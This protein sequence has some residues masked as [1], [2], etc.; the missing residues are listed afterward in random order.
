MKHIGNT[1]FENRAKLFL[2]VVVLMFVL[3]SVA[4]SSIECPIQNTVYTVYT[5]KDNAEVTDTLQDTLVVW[6]YNNKRDT[7]V[8]YNRGAKL[9]TFNIYMSYDAPEDTLFFT[10]WKDNFACTDTVWVAKENTPHFESVDCSA[11]FFH[12]ITSVRTTHYGIDTITINNASV[13]YDTSPEHFHIRFKT[14][15]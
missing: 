11:S 15:P 5:V 9:T 3:F 10:Q 14:R 4:C 13:S 8:L 7:V 2:S 6:T 1:L 12:T